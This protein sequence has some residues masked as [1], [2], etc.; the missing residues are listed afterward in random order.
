MR[1]RLLSERTVPI[2]LFGVTLLAYGVFIPWFGIYGDDP[3]YLYNYH[4][5]GAGSF[6]QFVAADRPFSGWIYMLVTPLFGTTIWLYH[7]LMLA[8]RWLSA[9]LLWWVLRLVW[10]THPRQAAWTALL[11]AIY[12]GFLQQPIAIQYILHFSVLNLF[13]LSLAAMLLAA[14]NPK[15]S[16]PWIGV[17]ILSAGVSLFSMEYFAGLEFLRPALLWLVLGQQQLNFYP[18]LKRTLRFW[19]PYLAVM[20]AFIYWRVV[21]FQFPTY[22]PTL[23]NALQESPPAALIGL[24]RRILVDLRTSVFAAWRQTLA[25][26]E[27]GQVFVFIALTLVTLTL[28]VYYLS[29]L[30]EK[31][32]DQA[33]HQS[34]WRREWAPGAILV[35]LIALI[36]GG[37]P[38]WFANVRLELSFPWDRSTLPFMLG[39]CLFVAGMVDLLIKPRFQPV[40][41]GALL[42][43]SV[44]FHH[45]NAII[46]RDEWRNLREYFWQLTWRA[47]DLEPGTIVVSDDVQLFRYGDNGLTPLLNWVYAPNQQ[48]AELPYKYFELSLRMGRAIPAVEKG[49]LVKHSYRGHSFESTTSKVLAVYQPQEGCLRVMQPQDRILP[50]LTDLIREALPL[51]NP[52]VI[53]IDAELPARPPAFMGPEP[54][55]DWC[56]YLAAA[57]LAQQKGDWQEAIAAGEVAFARSLGP[58][59]PAEY[60]PFIEAYAHQR[61][62]DEAAEL[63]NRAASGGDLTPMLCQTWRQINSA[64]S[65]SPDEQALLAS[66]Q[67]E[68]GCS[69]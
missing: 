8:L 26:P 38:I 33:E 20:A 55:A 54:N 30:P 36:A 60:I 52:E 51:S 27:N 10:S 40:L 13:L 47:P 28:G 11:F 1:Q 39:S 3:I 24:G 45:Q 6:P 69:P 56:W 41:L 23:L 50:G 4:L 59:D 14:R 37:L 32:T 35:S 34:F 19:L 5:L 2:A 43:L 31:S 25:L 22:Q 17:S 9:V 42:G 65:Q 57:E 67:A 68:L 66:I 46:Y 16:L 53:R 61:R 18:R 7:A 58:T 63:T 44:G 49:L 48:H 15:G 64:I 29:R 62:W 12:P 21:I